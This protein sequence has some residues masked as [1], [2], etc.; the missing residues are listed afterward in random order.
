MYEAYGDHAAWKTFDGRAM[1]AWEGLTDAVRSHWAAAAKQATL[2]LR[3][4]LPLDEREEL[5]IAHAKHYAEHFSGAG[6]VG[7]T[8][9]MLIAKLAKAL[10]L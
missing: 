9:F 4:D 7:H 5:K 2:I 8:S 6:D 10:R 1:P 3:K